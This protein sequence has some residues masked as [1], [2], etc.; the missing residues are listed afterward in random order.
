[1]A[2]TEVD[3]TQKPATLEYVTVELG[4]SLAPVVVVDDDFHW[5]GLDPVKIETAINLVKEEVT[6]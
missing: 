3:T 1:M 2:F 4:Y 5:S 6:G